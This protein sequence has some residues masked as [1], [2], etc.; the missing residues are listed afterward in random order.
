M[1][2]L[3]CFMFVAGMTLAGGAAAD[4]QNDLNA[5]SVNPAN[6]TQLTP[7]KIDVATALI[8]SRDQLL[9]H[10]AATPTSPI[11]RLSPI[12]RSNFI[13]SLVFTPRGL[14]SYSYV[15]LAGLS[16]ADAYSILSLFG[17]Q[18][19]INSIPGL[20]TTTTLDQA[21]NARFHAS[22]QSIGGKV[23]PMSDPRIDHIC[24]VRPGGSGGCVEE[25]GH[26][27][28]DGC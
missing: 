28:T 13:A 24:E 17:A 15:D 4:Q 16:V 9:T 3:A 12:A 1:K 27:C 26:R 14:G 25:A 19:T 11:Y 5:R 10:L 8:T 21:I 6:G 23:I 2:K 7:G 22:T 18:S 20:S